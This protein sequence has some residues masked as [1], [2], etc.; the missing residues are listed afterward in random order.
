M[1]LIALSFVCFA[2]AG[3]FLFLGSEMGALGDVPTLFS[4]LHDPIA[5]NRG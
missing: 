3:A 5:G 2:I 4:R 1:T